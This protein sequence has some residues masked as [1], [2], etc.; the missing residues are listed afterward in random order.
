MPPEFPYGK[1]QTSA[2]LG[3]LIRIK[4]KTDGVL[5]ARA[6][7]LAGVGVRFL[8]ELENGK[9][10]AELGLALQVLQ[11]LGLDVWVLPKGTKVKVEQA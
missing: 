7:G 11:R 9:P 4:R 2:E 8:S 3:A 5:Q 1:I 10:T 6:A